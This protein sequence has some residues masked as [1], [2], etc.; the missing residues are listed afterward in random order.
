[1]SAIY[2]AYTTINYSTTSPRNA[3]NQITK[4]ENN[5]TTFITSDSYIDTV[6]ISKEAID[7]NEMLQPEFVLEK[8]ID[9][10]NGKIRDG[11]QKKYW[12]DDIQRDHTLHISKYET[13]HPISTTLYISKYDATHPLFSKFIIPRKPT[14]LVDQ[15][16]MANNASLDWKNSIAQIDDRIKKIMDENNIT[17]TKNEML[18]FSINQDGIITIDKG[19][20]D[21]KRVLL[22]ELFNKDNELRASLLESHCYLK[23]S[24]PDGDYSSPDNTSLALQNA[25][26][27]RNYGVTVSDFEMTN[28]D[29]K[30]SGALPLKFKDGTNN[31]ELLMR[32]FKDDAATFDYIIQRLTLNSTTEY[33]YNFSHKNDVTIET[34]FG[35]QNGLN[36]SYIPKPVSV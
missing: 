31:D 32:M 30:L 2:T 9:S 20:S 36:K 35:T 26:L 6:E 21:D 27:L 3:T 1:M 7:A 23:F 4:S 16:D 18:N 5:P 24:N 28:H 33:K 10:Q 14:N 12:Y 11:M 8:I 25:Y 29:E 34:E 13:T 22:E 17:L 15:I 19:V